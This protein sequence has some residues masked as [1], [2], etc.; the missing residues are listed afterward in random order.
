VT[1]WNALYA[2]G[3]LKAGETLLVQG[4]GGV[5][6]FA[7]QF[8]RLIGA[9]VIATTSSSTKADKLLALGV[10]DVVNYREHSS[11]SDEVL[12]LTG[13]EGAHLVVEIGG[14]GTLAESI[15]S[16]RE[17]GRVVMVGLLTNPDE[18][19]SQAFMN[20]FMRDTTISSAHVGHRRSFEEMN[21]A[22]TQAN[23]RPAIDS[24]YDFS[25]AP[26]A[27]ERL[28]SNAHFGKVVIRHD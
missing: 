13:G 25:D 4:T 23:L 7:L 26:R 27:F 16:T 11:W 19:T 5:S 28:M 2:K 14:A 17:S 15:K 8:A 3:H 22:I 6:L 21:E 18:T 20:A 12:R 24:R 1:A 10:A 9:R